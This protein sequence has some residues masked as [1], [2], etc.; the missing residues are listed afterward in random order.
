MIASMPVEG[1]YGAWE[2][3]LPPS[4]E[5]RFHLDLLKGR[6][7]IAAIVHTHSTFATVLGIARKRI[8]PATTWWRSSAA[9]TYAWRTMRPTALRQLAENVV[10]AMQGRNGCLI[11]NHGMI[12]AGK[13]LDHA[14]WLAVELETIAKQYYHSLLIGGPVILP[15]PPSRKRAAPWTATA[16]RS[17]SE[18]C[19][20]PRP[21]TPPPPRRRGCHRPRRPCWRR[22][23]N[24][25]G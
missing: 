18:P 11:A 3:P 16:C 25:W 5:W 19:R 8:P 22:R 21:A 10:Q 4:T 7:D 15:D 6:R 14:M 17:A 9:T 2:G 20:A 13:D 1:E 12:A 24:G 23:S